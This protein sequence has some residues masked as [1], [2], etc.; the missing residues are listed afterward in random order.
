MNG[1]TL[2]IG[3][4]YD[5]IRVLIRL[6]GANMTKKTKNKKNEIKPEIIETIL[7]VDYEDEMKQSYIDYSMSVIIDRALPDV[8]DGLKP[9]H[10][11]TLFAMDGISNYPESPHKK[12]ARIVGETLGKFHP[13]GDSSVYGAMVRMAR[14]YSLNYPLVDGHGNFGSIDGDGAA[15]MRYTEARLTPLAM[16]MLGNLQKNSVS[17]KDNFDSTIKEPVVFPC[18]FPNL[19]VNGSSGI[20]VG[21]ATSI[22]PHNFEESV[23]AVMDNIDDADSDPLKRIKGPDFPTGGIIV[24]KDDLKDIYRTGKGKIKLR[25]KLEVEDIGYGKKNIIIKEIPYTFAG[26]KTKLI[27]QLITLVVDKKMDEISDIRD[28]SSMHGMRI[29]LEVRKGVDIDRLIN[30]LYR[31][32]RLEDTF[33][34]NMLAVEN[35][36]PH[37]HS[38]KEMVVSYTKFLKDIHRKELEYDLK[39]AEDKDEIIKGFIRAIDVIDLIIEII[40]N[41]KDV[42]MVKKCLHK[43]KTDGINFKTKKNETLASKLLFT[44]RQTQAILNMQLQRLVLLE[45]NKLIKEEKEIEEDIKRLNNI[46]KNELV[47]N[48]YIK[49]DLERILKI[50]KRKRRTELTHL[51]GDT[52]LPEEEEKEEDVYLLIDKLRY[53][54]VIDEA[55]F[56]KADEDTLNEY[57]HIIKTKNTDRLLI[58]DHLGNLEQV[59]IKDFPFAKLKDKGIPVEHIVETKKPILITPLS[60]GPELLL[61]VTKNGLVKRVPRTEFDINRRHSHYTKLLK[62]DSIVN[63][64]ELEEKDKEIELISN[65]NKHLRFYIDEI[66]IQKRNATGVTGMKFPKSETIEIVRLNFETQKEKRKRGSKAKEK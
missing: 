25:A 62:G 33:G 14:D 8:R 63:I 35:N 30:N 22:P 38:L 54:K 19:L 55:S 64:T 42:D 6:R 9:V 32:S 13:H 56:L 47:F 4:N 7:D 28:E 21:M 50:N 12:S 36:I 39:K 11:R 24:N 51:N 29:V 27:E 41:S 46:L 48:K 58:F 59:K 23:L 31:R 52:Y 3:N 20:A 44:E 34:V 61:M 65:K 49:D 45:L 60:I 18:K 57:M 5:K 53:S 17:F 40:R 37:T 1:Q 26:S 15:S 43:G 10:R 16:E 66:S 2:T